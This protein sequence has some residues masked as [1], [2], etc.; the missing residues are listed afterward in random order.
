[1]KAVVTMFAGLAALALPLTQ[2]LAQTD[3]VETLR[4]RLSQIDTLQAE[5]TQQ[6]FD[7]R[8]QLQ[9]ELQGDLFL[10]R[11]HYLR[12]E[13]EQPDHSIM[14]ADGDSVWYYN[15]FIEQMSIFDQ[16]QNLEQN[17]MLVLLS[18]DDDAWADFNVHQQDG[19]WVIEEAGSEISGVSL[20]VAFDEHDAI[21]TLRVNDGQGQVSVFELSSVVLNETLDEA[22]FTLDAPEGTEIDDQRAS[23]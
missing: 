10:K 3:D 19:L 16:A 18:D 21:Q 15:A 12:W 13:T 11:P 5:F 8:D 4:A 17:P 20:A 7:E 23:R 9:E 22:Q 1:M 2:T 6:V 14:V